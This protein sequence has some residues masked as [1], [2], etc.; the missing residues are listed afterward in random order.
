MILFRRLQSRLLPPFPMLE[1]DLTMMPINGGAIMHIDVC[2]LLLRQ[3]LSQVNLLFKRLSHLL[4]TNCCQLMMHV[5]VVKSCGMHVPLVRIYVMQSCNATC[6]SLAMDVRSIHASTGE[7][8]Y[9]IQ[10]ASTARVADMW[11]LPESGQYYPCI[12]I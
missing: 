6:L 9:S 7:Y 3:A 10:E 12:L 5:S 2:W 1:D 4:S 11:I 8:T